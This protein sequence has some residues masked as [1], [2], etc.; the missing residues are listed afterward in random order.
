MREINVV[1]AIALGLC[2]DDDVA[3]KS[4]EK[5]LRAGTQNGSIRLRVGEK[6]YETNLRRE[7]DRRVVVL[8]GLTPLQVGRWVALGFPALRGVDPGPNRTGPRGER[9]AARPGCAAAAPRHRRL[10]AR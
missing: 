6:W 8:S 9:R 3:Q 10:A 5:L 1:C 7:S 4:G 2:G